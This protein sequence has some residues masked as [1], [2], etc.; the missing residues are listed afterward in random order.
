MIQKNLL[1]KE[2]DFLQFAK[3]GKER[4]N[5]LF[6]TFVAQLTNKELASLVKDNKEPER[7]EQMTKLPKDRCWQRRWPSRLESWL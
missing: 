1:T 6:S 5:R 7:R 3:L 4:A 2:K